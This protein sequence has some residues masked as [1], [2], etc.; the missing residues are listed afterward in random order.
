MTYSIEELFTPPGYYNTQTL[1]SA[2]KVTFVGDNV[3]FSNSSYKTESLNKH[4]LEL[5]ENIAR[6]NGMAINLKYPPTPLVGAKMDGVTNDT[7]IVDNVLAY[8]DSIGGGILEI[9][10]GTLL[11]DFKVPYSNIYIKGAGIDRTILKSYTTN[12]I[13]LHLNGVNKLFY[14]VEN[15]SIIDSGIGLKLG[16][17]GTEISRVVIKNV[18][19]YNCTTYA[20]QLAKIVNGSFENVHL[21]NSELGLYSDVNDV[22]TQCTFINCYFRLN[23]GYGI[24]LSTGKGHT[25]IGCTIESND[26]TGMLLVGNTSGGGVQLL[27]FISCWLENN[28]TVTSIHTT[29]SVVLDGVS[30]SNGAKL[31][32]FDNCLFDN[33]VGFTSIF[34]NRSKDCTVERCQFYGKPIYE[35]VGYSSGIAQTFNFNV[36]NPAN[37]SENDLDNMPAFTSSGAG[38]TLEYSIGRIIYSNR[39]ATV[40]AVTTSGRSANP[41]VFEMCFDKTLNKPIY[42]DGLSWIDA[43]G[44]VV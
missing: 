34:S 11:A 23:R 3:T 14:N 44:A 29:S 43:T 32:K 13:A 36:L 21:Y 33:K 4:T 16:G 39:R 40:R 37:P 38:I 15:L 42:W 20:M 2:D 41:V 26:S 5:A 27:R 22:S 9:P 25:F 10:E 28:A 30:G 18:F 24:R 17:A 12:G 8:L 19:I 35:A 7:V 6:E 1:T 31:V